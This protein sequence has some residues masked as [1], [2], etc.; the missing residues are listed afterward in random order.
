MSPVSGKGYNSF[1]RTVPNR[2][3][4]QSRTNKEELPGDYKRIVKVIDKDALLVVPCQDNPISNRCGCHGQKIE[5]IEHGR[6][7]NAADTCFAGE[8]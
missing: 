7:P 1:R 5:Q 6:T 4:T 8:K 2:A 3:H